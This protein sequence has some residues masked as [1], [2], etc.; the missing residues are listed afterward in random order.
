MVRVNRADPLN[1]FDQ[2]YGPNAA[3]T[4]RLVDIALADREYVVQNFKDTDASH[5]NEFALTV[6]AVDTS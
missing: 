2:D 3:T 5:P 4:R 1:G 6:K